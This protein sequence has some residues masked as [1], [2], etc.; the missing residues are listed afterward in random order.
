L[1]CISITTG[2]RRNLDQK[3]DT[4]LLFAT[5]VIVLDPKKGVCVD[6]VGRDAIFGIEG[7]GPPVGL[8]EQQLSLDRGGEET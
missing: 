2:E 6:P 5:I 1:S 7:P 4:E 8:S 3:T